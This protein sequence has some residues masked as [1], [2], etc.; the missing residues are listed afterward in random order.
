MKCQKISFEFK[1]VELSLKMSPLTIKN[2][3]N[4]NLNF[5][6]WQI[7]VSKVLKPKKGW[8]KE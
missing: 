5:E 3:K 1:I 4:F 8:N 7:T 2:K 6:I